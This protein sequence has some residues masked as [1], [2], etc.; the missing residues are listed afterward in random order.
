MALGG[1]ATGSMKASDDDMAAAII[2]T[3]G[4]IPRAKESEAVTGKKIVAV[5][6]M[7]PAIVF[8]GLVPMKNPPIRRKIIWFPY[9]AVT[10][11]TSRAPSKGKRIIGRSEV[12]GMGIASVSHQHAILRCNYWNPAS[13]IPT[14][15]DWFILDA[16]R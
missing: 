5:A 16:I 2:S 14:T 10:F 8:L 3:R 7:N 11:P 6:A 9:S 13:L 1:V 15:A 12:A 4:S